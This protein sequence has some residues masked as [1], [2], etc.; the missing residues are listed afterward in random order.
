MKEPTSQIRNSETIELLNYGFTNYKIKTILSTK[1]DLGYVEVLNGKQ[2]AVNIKLIE[3]ATNL[4]SINEEKNYTYNIKVEPIKAPVKVG[5]NVGYLEII[6]DGKVL[7]TVN[8]T[9]TE[10]VKKA[11]L[12][13]LYKRNLNTFLIGN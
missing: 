13:D 6:S 5:Q 2:K 8:I 9:V 1:N 3:D 11:N 12:W 7:K 4:E 10:D